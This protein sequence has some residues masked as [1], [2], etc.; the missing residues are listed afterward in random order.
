MKKKPPADINEVIGLLPTAK[1]AL[2]HSSALELLVATILSAQANDK[3]VNKVTEQLFKKY[4][5][6]EDYAGK[7]WQDLAKDISS[8]NFFNNKA[9]SIV[10]A[11]R[12][13]L[14]KFGGKVPDSMENLI[15][16][17]GVSR[18]TANVVLSTWF[19]KD[20][21]IVVDT[22]VMR[23][24]QLLGLTKNKVREKIEEDLMRITPR[25]H[26]GQL[27]FK[28]IELGRKTCKARRPDCPNCVLNKICPSA[29]LR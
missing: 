2:N 8:I 7:T 9:K 5:R 24:S 17:P 19:E 25:E 15:Q 6:A 29:K 1:C 12:M 26:W 10:G 18:K 14:E 16:L 20:E 11:C 28:L 3:T 27:S 13:I 21:G 22:H 23:I 4:M